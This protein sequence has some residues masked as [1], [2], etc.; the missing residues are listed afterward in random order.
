LAL[1]YFPTSTPDTASKAFRR[2]INGCKGLPEAMADKGYLPGIK[3]LPPMIVETI[4]QYLG[5]P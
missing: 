5:E 2:L 3:T 1:Q 4:T